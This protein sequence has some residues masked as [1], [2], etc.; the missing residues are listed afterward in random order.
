MI[1]RPAQPSERPSEDEKMIRLP[2]SVADSLKQALEKAMKEMKILDAC[3]T[4]GLSCVFLY[5]L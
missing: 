2:T 1:I 4:N 5:E 3:P